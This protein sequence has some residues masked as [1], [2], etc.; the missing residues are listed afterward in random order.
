MSL[1][2]AKEERN[3]TFDH[4]TRSHKSERLKRSQR[5]GPEEERVRRTRDV[6]RVVS[7]NMTSRRRDVLYHGMQCKDREVNE[8]YNYR[9]LIMLVSVITCTCWS[10]CRTI[11][12]E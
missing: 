7:S 8:P 10:D 11:T 2:A 1:V 12:C 9:K 6:R 4:Y 3:G 5:M